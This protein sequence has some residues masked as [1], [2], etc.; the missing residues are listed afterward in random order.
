MTMHMKR[1]LAAGVILLAVGGTVVA[2]NMAFKV[3]WPIATGDPDIYD[4]SLPWN[5]NYA[6][7]SDIFNDIS[8]SSGCAAASVTHFNPD[9]S[10]CSWIGPGSCEI[11]VNE[12]GANIR[13]TTSGPCGAWVIVGSH[14]P[15]AVF[16]F[17]QADPS[18]YGVSVPYHT[19]AM[20]LAGLY[21]DIPNAASV[22]VFSPDQS[23]CSWIGPG[24]C[25]MPLTLG[26]GVRVTVGLAGTTW[27]PSHY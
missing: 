14:D 1:L 17:A 26:Q 18:I 4:I 25:N 24:G 19:T 3:V 22:T 23:S 20:D 10:S 21:N 16:T 11:V 12:K 7:L 13:V 5:N 8:A 2:S 6:K 15:N 9:Q 27:K